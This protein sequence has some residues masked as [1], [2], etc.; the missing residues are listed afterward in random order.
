MVPGVWLYWIPLGAGDH[1]VRVCGKVFEALS[2]RAQRRQPGDLYH[3]ALEVVVPDGRFIIEMT[4][5]PAGGADDRGVVAEGP[6]GV[7]PLGRLRL[8]RYEIRRWENGVIPDVSFAVEM[9]RVAGVVP[10]LHILSLV[11]SVPSLVW[12]RDEL[13]ARDMWNSNSVTSWLLAGA[14]VEV[15]LNRPPAGVGAPG[16]HAGLVAAQRS[17]NPRGIPAVE[18]A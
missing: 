10:G 3:S 7:R 5:I 9:A 11:P 2:A 13:G 15:S 8:F 4:P 14:G 18:G 16:W 1:V 6:V 17:G 12:G